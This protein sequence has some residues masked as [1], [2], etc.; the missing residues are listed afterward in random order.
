M[1]RPNPPVGAVVVLNNEIVGSGFHRAAGKPHAEVVALKSAGI[2]AKG[3]TLYV[4]LEPC[5]TSGRTPPCTATIIQSGIARVVVGKKDPN[6]RHNG[7]GL[8]LL[9]KNGMK[10]EQGIC[11][12]EAAQILAPFAKWI[13]SGKPYLTLKLGMSLDGKIADF[14]GRSK[15]IT[16]AKSRDEV[17]KLRQKVDAILVGRQT[18]CMDDPSLLSKR[19]LSNNPFRVI[20]DSSGKLPLNAVILNDH[21]VHKTIIATTKHCP[22]LRR[23]QY[24]AKG[25]QVWELPVAAGQVSLKR[26]FA[27]LGKM[28]LL[29]V[30]SEGG[31]EL[32]YGLIKSGLVDEYLFFVAPRIIGGS[33]TVSAVEGKGWAL[34]L[35]PRVRFVECK[36]VG[37][38]ILIRAIPEM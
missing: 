32:A 11:T 14:Q 13:I 35:S 37:E 1:T 28:G 4:T 25:A 31:A 30:L 18:A 3:A 22:Q 26:L 2:K 12:E 20:V 23:K 34:T 7:R 38:D 19:A 21:Y 36:R 5:S 8:L 17:Q 27:R 10:V 16:C 24:T 15:W 29:H 33:N 6:P 9:K